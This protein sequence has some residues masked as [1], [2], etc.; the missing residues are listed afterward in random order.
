M[1]KYKILTAALAA[2]VLGGASALA[3]F[4][5]HNGD[6]LVA[7]GNGGTTDVIVDLGAISNF[8]TPYNTFSKDLSSVLNSTFG[9]VTTSLYWA[10]LGVND[11]T[12]GGN[13]SVTQTDPYTVWASKK[14][15]NPAVPGNAPYVAGSSAAQQLG[16]SDIQTI[17]NLTNPSTPG[18]TDAGAG[19]ELVNTSLGGFSSLMTGSYN[20][21]LQGDW[22][23]NTL[24]K[25]AGTSDLFQSNP[26]DPYSDHANYLGSVSLDSTGVF[27]VTT[28]PEPSTYAMLGSGVLALLALRR[29]K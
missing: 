2:A 14:R 22:S 29:R 1:K 6:M 24:N 25:G 8:Q 10:V 11:T 23:W 18:V 13:S 28:V 21:N 12:L 15:I 4:N 19:I 9:S 5:Y 16:V 17:A 7:F 3:Q 26:G 27:T 20:G